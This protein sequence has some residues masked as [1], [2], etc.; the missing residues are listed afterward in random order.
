MNTRVQGK[1]SFW[2][3]V[4]A[5]STGG[6][7]ITQCQQMIQADCTEDGEITCPRC[8]GQETI[9]Q[10][11]VKKIVRK[12]KKPMW[13]PSRDLKRETTENLS[14][15]HK[16]IVAAQEWL[17]RGN[18]GQFTEQMLDQAHMAYR[19]LTELLA[20]HKRIEPPEELLDE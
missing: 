8:L 6:K 3:D 5:Q 12:S 4:V 7:N 17:H 14:H 18:P 20:L 16:S 13:R 15:A 10:P 2:H 1:D 9:P 11:V 19:F